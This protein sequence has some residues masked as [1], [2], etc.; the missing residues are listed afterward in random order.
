VTESL[1]DD[2]L[3]KVSSVASLFDRSPYT[4]RQWLKD[5]TLKGVKINKQ[6]FVRTSEVNRLAQELYG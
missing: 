1:V 2:P 6:W 4:I 5:G 3:L